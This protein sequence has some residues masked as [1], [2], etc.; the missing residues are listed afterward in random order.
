MLVLIRFVYS[1]GGYPTNSRFNRRSLSN[2]SVH[3]TSNEAMDAERHVPLLEQSSSQEAAVDRRYCFSSGPSLEESQAIA[4]QNTTT[5]TVLSHTTDD[6]CLSLSL[7][8]GA[9]DSGGTRSHS[10]D[11]SLQSLGASS[12]DHLSHSRSSRSLEDNDTGI[13]NV[14]QSVDRWEETTPTTPI[15]EVARSDSGPVVSFAGCLST[16]TP[17]RE[18]GELVM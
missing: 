9:L 2:G 14:D 6:T 10:H 8:C 18:S 1:Q 3:R 15:A 16:T 4:M 7:N 13:C 5:T 17:I 11:S 12:E